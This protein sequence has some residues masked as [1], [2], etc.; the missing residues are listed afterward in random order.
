[1]Y[2]ILII[3]D[4]PQFLRLMQMRLVKLDYIVDIAPNGLAGLRRIKVQ[5][6]D[7]VIADLFLPVIEGREVCAR[8]KEEFDIP[9]IVIT[10]AHITNFSSK[11]GEL[12]IG[13]ELYPVQA[14]AVLNKTDDFEFYISQIEILL[15]QQGK[16]NIAKTYQHQILIVDDNKTLSQLLEDTLEKEYQILLAYNGKE[17]LELL[18]SNKPEIVLT[19]LKIADIEGIE[20][21]KYIRKNYPDIAIIVMTAYGSEK[22]AVDVMKLG[23]KD[24]ISKPIDIKYLKKIIRHI[25]SEQKSQITTNK[26]HKQLEE[27]SQDLIVRVSQLEIYNRNLKLLFNTALKIRLASNIQDGI[28]DDDN[29]KAEMMDAADLVKV[30]TYVVIKGSDFVSQIVERHTH[31]TSAKTDGPKTGIYHL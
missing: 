21:I 9:I 20:L 23:V 2:R 15:G 17:A 29:K 22:I 10:S 14:D 7:L 13:N 3:D 12:I 5:K 18:S 16:H 25:S 19:N 4:N 26:L 31:K 8:I 30:F 1:M 27:I 6:P 24:Y 28:D 11:T